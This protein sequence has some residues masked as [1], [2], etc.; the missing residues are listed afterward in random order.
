ME[1]VGNGK[2][3]E[4][5]KSMLERIF[6]SDFARQWIERREGDINGEVEF[7]GRQL[8]E[9]EWRKDLVSEFFEQDLEKIVAVLPE[10]WT[11]VKEEATDALDSYVLESPE[12]LEEYVLSHAWT[13]GLRVPFSLTAYLEGLEKALQKTLKPRLD[14]AQRVGTPLKA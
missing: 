2:R 11:Q 3:E 5:N 13:E 14:W 6:N 10:I 4:H 12:K 7:Y 1:N 9:A 8:T